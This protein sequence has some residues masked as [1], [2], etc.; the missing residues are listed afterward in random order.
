MFD[1]RL[2]QKR[3]I[4]FL[5]NKIYHLIF[6]EKFSKKINFNFDK[7]N[8]IDLINYVINKYDYKKYLEI[9]CHNNEVFNQIKI[10]KIGVDPVSGGNFK[11]TSDKFFE[12]N[13]ENFDCIFIDGMHEYKQVKKDIINSI[14]FLNKNGIIILHDC[15]PKS[16]SHQRVPRTRYSWNGDVWKAVVEART[17][18]HVDTFTVLSDQGLGIIKNKDNSDLLDLEDISFEKLK[19]K[20]FYDNYPKIMRT[21]RYNDFLEII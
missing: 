16:I 13:K 6:S 20:F 14:K 17:W 15:L 10:E 21:I 2:E 18:K 5:V 1:N 8:R 3:K 12:Q 11:G 19:F 9:G 7:Q 4:N